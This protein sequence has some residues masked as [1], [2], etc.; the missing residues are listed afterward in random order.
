MKYIEID[1]KREAYSAD[2]VAGSTLTLEELIGILEELEEEVGEDTPVIVS[3]DRGYTYGSIHDNYIRVEETEEE[4]EEEDE[5]EEF[6]VDDTF[7]ESFEHR[8]CGE[9]EEP[10]T[11]DVD[12]LDEHCLHCDDDDEDDDFDCDDDFGEHKNSYDVDEAYSFKGLNDRFGGKTL[13]E[14]LRPRTIKRNKK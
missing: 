9:D 10:E 13:T 12:G 6:E 5:E 3:H 1:A 14:S 7:E 2:E 8:A 11:D 4:P